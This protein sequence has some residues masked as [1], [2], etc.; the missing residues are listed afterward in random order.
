MSKQ[1]CEIYA[2]SY[3]NQKIDLNRN[4]PDKHF[5]SRIKNLD[6]QFPYDMRAMCEREGVEL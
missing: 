6:R 5:N 2:T 4:T 3:R 1:L